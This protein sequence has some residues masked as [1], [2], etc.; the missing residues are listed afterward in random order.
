M[1]ALAVRGACMSRLRDREFSSDNVIVYVC[2][3]CRGD[4]GLGVVHRIGMVY[5]LSISIGISEVVDGGVERWLSMG[6]GEQGGLSGQWVF[7]DMRMAWH[8][9][10]DWVQASQFWGLS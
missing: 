7:I 1:F 4:T 9:H 2:A 8:L 10:V 6:E 5:I 3:A